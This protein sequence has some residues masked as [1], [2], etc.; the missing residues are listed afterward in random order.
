MHQ[1]RLGTTALGQGWPTFAH[2]V[3]I[4]PNM[5]R[6]EPYPRIFLVTMLVHIISYLPGNI[7]KYK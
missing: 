2:H 3:P 6:D 7:I 4:F 1:K 5:S